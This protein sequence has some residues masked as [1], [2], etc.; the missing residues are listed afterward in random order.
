MH[1]LT[2]LAELVIEAS[3]VF[4][5]LGVTVHSFSYPAHIAYSNC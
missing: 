2:H 5:S 1:T 3:N 4:L